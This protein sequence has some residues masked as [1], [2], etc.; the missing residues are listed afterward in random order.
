MGEAVVVGQLG[1]GR[2]MRFFEAVVSLPLELLPP[3]SIAVVTSANR[4]I[5]SRSLRD[6]RPV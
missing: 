3:G 4:E 1:Y 2:A 5:F 6:R